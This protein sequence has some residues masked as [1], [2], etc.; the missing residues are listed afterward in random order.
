MIGTDV[1]GQP[2]LVIQEAEESETILG[3][4]DAIQKIES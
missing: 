4:Q 3:L 2:Q 1:H